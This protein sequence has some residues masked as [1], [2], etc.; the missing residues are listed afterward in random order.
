MHSFWEGGE[1]VLRVLLS[2]GG[3]RLSREEPHGIFSLQR[4]EKS[5]HRS[6]AGFMLEGQG[7]ELGMAI[8]DTAMPQT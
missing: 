7:W 4:A 8:V 3:Q 2:K 5:A 6:R 1:E